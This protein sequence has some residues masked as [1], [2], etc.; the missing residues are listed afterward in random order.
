MLFLLLLLLLLLLSFWIVRAVPKEREG[1]RIIEPTI[2]KESFNSHAL[3]TIILPTF[4]DPVLA[5]RKWFRPSSKMSDAVCAL[6]EN[7]SSFIEVNVVV[8]QMSMS[9]RKEKEA[10]NK[11]MQTLATEFPERTLTTNSGLFPG[12]KDEIWN[13]WSFSAGSNN[14]A[15]CSCVKAVVYVSHSTTRSHFNSLHGYD[16]FDK[17]VDL[18]LTAFPLRTK[19]FLVL[20]DFLVPVLWTEKN[21]NATPHDSGGFMQQLLSTA[22]RNEGRVSAVQCSILSKR[23]FSN[24]KRNRENTTNKSGTQMRDTVVVEEERRRRKGIFPWQQLGEGGIFLQQEEPTFPVILQRY[25]EERNKTYIADYITLDKGVFVSYGGNWNRT[26]NGLFLTRWFNG[27]NA[28]DERVQTWEGRVDAVS[29][30]CTLFHRGVYDTVGGFMPSMRKNTSSRL[31]TRGWSLVRETVLPNDPEKDNFLVQKWGLQNSFPTLWPDIMQADDMMGWDFSFRLQSKLPDW[32]V[33]SSKA[34]AIA[35]TIPMERVNR[36]RN[37][38]PFFNIIS[39]TMENIILSYYTPSFVLTGDFAKRWGTFA[40]ELFHR[41]AGEPL[42][43]K[44][45]PLTRNIEE[46]EK[47]PI[48][49]LRVLANYGVTRCSGMMME[50]THYFIPLQQ[51]LLVVLW[52]YR[53]LWCPGI[54]QGAMDALYRTQMGINRWGHLAA[55][56]QEPIEKEEEEEEIENEVDKLKIGTTINTSEHNIYEKNSVVYITFLH[57]SPFYVDFIPLD[58]VFSE[59]RIARILTENSKLLKKHVDSINTYLDELWVTCDFFKEVYKRSGVR[60]ELIHVIPESVDPYI[61]DPTHFTPFDGPPEEW[62]QSHNGSRVDYWTN[63]PDNESLLIKKRFIFLSVFKWEPRKGWDILLSAYW[64]AFGPGTPLHDDVCLYIKTTFLKGFSSV[65]TKEDLERT[66]WNWAMHT[67]KISN[68]TSLSQFPRL[69]IIYEGDLRTDD[70]YRL[71]RS[72]DA[73]VL[74]TRGEGWGVP[75]ME[76]MSMELPVITTNWAG[77]TA[78]ATRDNSFLI[79]LDGLEELPKDSAYGSIEGRKWA[80]PSV[81]ATAEL[82]VYVVQNREHARIVGKRARQDVVKMFSEEVVADMINEHLRDIA[83]KVVQERKNKWSWLRRTP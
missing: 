80:I 66:L 55:W 4:N 82:M 52:G 68:F 22:S 14:T 50:G 20:A 43:Q 27:Y 8:V 65:S 28:L 60:E 74:P 81:N 51:R 58:Q 62:I 69:V 44:K 31:G 49:E 39:E 32:E 3:V 6:D 16:A 71:Y 24:S 7:N 45:I 19:Y 11:I 77:S 26:V 12:I 75:A 59:Y 10:L 76:A 46:K 15:F 23:P 56:R 78:F 37:V 30:F 73:F 64:K 35:W 61:I 38:K 5:L 41:R 25:W 21:L 63:R 83:R 18:G 13:S 42:S 67:A 1:E 17:Y 57:N 33:W 53:S 40:G 72:S 54:P 29:S 70:M 34:M 9:H 36:F 48:I 47:L 79:P 2:V